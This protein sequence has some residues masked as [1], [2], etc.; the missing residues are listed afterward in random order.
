[1]C[2]QPNEPICVHCRP[3]VCRNLKLPVIYLVTEYLAGVHT[4][5]K[6]LL[7]SCILHVTQLQ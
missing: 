1:M 3:C 5:G 6:R 2:E 7:N 4:T